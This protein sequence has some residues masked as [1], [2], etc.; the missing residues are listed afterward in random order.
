MERSRSSSRGM[1]LLG[2]VALRLLLRK[3][4]RSHAERPHGLPY[5]PRVGWPVGVLA[6]VVPG[7][8]RAGVDGGVSNGRNRRLFGLSPRSART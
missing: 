6:A 5:T 8:K 3:A 1:I 2:S 4:P 7:T